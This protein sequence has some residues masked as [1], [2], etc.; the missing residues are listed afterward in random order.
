MLLFFVFLLCPYVL[1]AVVVP[2]TSQDVLDNVLCHCRGLTDKEIFHL[3]KLRYSIKRMD[4]YYA[5]YHANMVGDGGV[6]YFTDLLHDSVVDPDPSLSS[7]RFNSQEVG[8]LFNYFFD[9]RYLPK[10]NL[11]RVIVEKSCVHM[12]DVEMCLR[13]SAHNSCVDY[14]KKHRHDYGLVYKYL[15]VLAS[16]HNIIQFVSLFS[17]FLHLD[18]DIFASSK[19]NYLKRLYAREVIFHQMSDYFQDAYDILYSTYNEKRIRSINNQWLLGWLS[20]EFLSDH[21]KSLYHFHEFEQLVR[22]PVSVSRA[23]YWLGHTYEKMGNIREA[24]SWY[25]RGAIYKHLFYGQMSL[26]KLHQMSNVD[27]SYN[28]NNIYNYSPFMKTEEFLSSIHIFNKQPSSHQSLLKALYYFAYIKEN[29]LVKCIVNYIIRKDD[30]NDFKIMLRIAN[31]TSNN[32]LLVLVTKYLH[33]SQH[34][35]LLDSLYPMDHHVNTFSSDLSNSWLLSIMRQESE[36]NH[37][38]ISNSGAVGVMQLMPSVAKSLFRDIKLEYKQKLLHNPICNIQ[39]G[40]MLMHKLYFGENKKSFVLS[41]GA[42]NAGTANVSVWKNTMGD[43]QGT[44]D[45]KVKWIESIPFE[46]TRDYVMYVIA[47]LNTYEMLLN[48]MNINT[49]Y[50]S[51]Q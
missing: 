28:G 49:I 6:V 1:F 14:V 29:C 25:K 40:T 38:A 2:A 16:E 39:L 23:N 26:Y 34:V 15:R 13:F 37:M 27:F 35:I 21:H 47:N 43:F 24:I 4:W 5:H 41:A 30:I 10:K 36:F 20:L 7:N 18:R 8:Y 12:P 3:E 17:E 42:Y 46:E 45:E 51:L 48:E 44:I 32:Y 31:M 11:K 33:N 19:W 9:P 50:Q 22:T